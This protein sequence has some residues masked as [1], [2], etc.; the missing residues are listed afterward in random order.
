[1][2]KKYF[3]WFILLLIIS[4]SNISTEKTHFA[5]IEQKL[6]ANDFDGAIQLLESTKNI[7]YSKKDRVLYYLDLGLLYHYA[8][9][10]EKSNEM[11]TRAEEAIKELYTKS[12]SKAI[13]SI[14]LND[15]IL[16]YEGEDYE[17]IYLNVIK[18]LNYLNMKNREDAF[19]EIRKI[20]EKLAYLETKYKK[21]ADEYNKSGKGK[22][23]FK[24]GENK[25][26]DSALARLFSAL[27]YRS[28]G[29][30]DDARIDLKKFRKVWKT[31][32]I[33]YDYKPV[34][35]KNFLDGK[36]KI[37]FV[38]LI[39]KSPDKKAKTL[40]IHTEKD[41]IFIATTKENIKGKTNLK[42]LNQLYW[43][44]MKAGYHFKFQL[45]FIK[46]KPSK[47]SSIKISIDGYQDVKPNLVENI[48]RVAVITF[49]IKEPLIYFKTITRAVL[50]GLVAA[51][52]K[53]KL[54]QKIDNPLLAFAMRTAIDATVDATEH[55]DLRISHYFPAKVY[56]KELNLRPGVYRMR[57]D[58]LDKSNTVIYSDIKDSVAVSKNG[59]NLVES[60]YVQ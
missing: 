31:E 21:M 48:Q 45:P 36:T 13:A 23:K 35:L 1:M 34:Q 33:I 47:V 38:C 60:Y 41:H 32:P 2:M 46:E 39:G 17:N 40:Y 49:K 10:Y 11:L 6:A 15:N 3:I 55:A 24:P 7:Y 18:A 16:D 12:V 54:S 20:N 25:F 37:D 14:L 9:K 5:T 28:D 29:E 44:G 50:K 8:K 58:Y 43:P 22:L 4:C 56:F 19:V 30:F 26:K 59:L 57:V 52:Q 53:Q 27:L 51:N 42:N